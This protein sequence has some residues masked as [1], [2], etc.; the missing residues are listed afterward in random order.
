L[1]KNVETL[2]ARLILSDQ[3][4]AEDTIVIDVEDGHL[5]AYVRAAE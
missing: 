5:G 3:V 2:S 1:Q 4:H